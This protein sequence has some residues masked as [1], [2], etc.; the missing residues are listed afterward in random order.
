V[1]YN[2]DREVNAKGVRYVGSCRL[3]IGLF[4]YIMSYPLMK[5]S[6]FSTELH[7][8]VPTHTHC[9]LYHGS[10]TSTTHRTDL[11]PVNVAA[12]SRSFAGH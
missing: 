10:K 11:I 6:D 9:I 7:Y 3:Q 12:W 5:A 2:Q 1:P 4:G 8:F